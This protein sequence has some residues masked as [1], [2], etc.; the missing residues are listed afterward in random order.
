MTSTAEG[1]RQ[2]LTQAEWE[3]Q[4]QLS[5]QNAKADLERRLAEEQAE[6]GL[7]KAANKDMEDRLADMLV[8]NAGLRRKD[9]LDREEIIALRN[10]RRREWAATNELKERLKLAE[11]RQH[12]AV[13][14]AAEARQAAA[15]SDG[16]RRHSEAECARLESTRDA[17]IEEIEDA[18]EAR[19]DR[20]EE[21]AR[22]SRE[23]ALE[24]AGRLRRHK[25]KRRKAEA[26]R[27]ELRLRKQ[28]DDIAINNLRA[29]LDA[30]PPRE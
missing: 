24:M 13:Q 1:L 15:I 6:N 23:E 26:E 10:V 11:H 28:A 14:E 16:D 9:A 25:R 30:R 12:A 5:L 27:D 17:I 29:E 19:V 22:H 4:Q 7:L 2:L 21:E 18:A 20:A 3:L 8:E